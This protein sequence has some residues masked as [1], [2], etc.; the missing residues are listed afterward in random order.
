MGTG[1]GTFCCT[2]PSQW[3]L[4]QRLTSSL[5]QRTTRWCLRRKG[6]GARSRSPLACLAFT[7]STS[8]SSTSSSSPAGFARDYFLRYR[9]HQEEAARLQ[10]EN[11]RKTYELEEARQL[12]LSMIPDRVPSLPGLEIAVH[13]QTATEVG[14]DYYDFHVADDGALTVAIGDATGHGL[15]AGMMVAITKGLFKVLADGPDLLQIISKATR[16][17]K[18][19]NLHRLYMAMTLARLKGDRL[20][21]VAAGMP[22]PLVYRSAD[23]RVEELEAKGMP[24]GSLEQFPYWQEEVELQAGDTVLLMSDGF[25]ELFNAHGEMM[26]YSKAKALFSEMAE[27]AP[28][29]V[30]QQLKREAAAWSG[31]PIHDDITFVVIKVRSTSLAPS[32]TATTSSA[33]LDGED[34][35]V[36]E[37]EGILYP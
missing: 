20:Q 9:K 17:I 7:F 12:Q 21:V 31:G 33:L 3:R 26:G 4:R 14:G 22:M 16:T 2:S 23:H 24:L 34:E 10:G 25:P 30:V 19:M 18:E 15:K 37:P 36:A 1:S 6:T 5:T 27:H 29:E 8:S 32:A 35:P 13:M 28:S 11:L